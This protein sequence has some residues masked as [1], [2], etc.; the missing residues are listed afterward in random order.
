[1]RLEFTLATKKAATLRGNY[2]C[3]AHLIWSG[4]VC[5]NQSS[6]HDHI[7]EASLGGKPTLENC[8]ALCGRCH[9]RKTKERR[10]EMDKTV[11]LERKQRG[12]TGR[13][14]KIKSRGFSKW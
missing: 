3:E 10:P 9:K 4:F 1:M 8:A 5:T 13:K 12:W 7:L 14:Q 11:R 6:E 2:K